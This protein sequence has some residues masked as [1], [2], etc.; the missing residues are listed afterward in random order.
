MN[1][2]IVYQNIIKNLPVELVKIINEYVDEETTFVRDKIVD[3]LENKNT[4]YNKIKHK[5]IVDC[6]FLCNNIR[7]NFFN[8]NQDLLEIIE[9][10]KIIP[11]VFKKRKTFNHMTYIDYDSIIQIWELLENIKSPD[12]PIINNKINIHCFYM[13]LILLDFKIHISQLHTYDILQFQGY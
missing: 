1:S 9:L 8:Y 6:I 13:A 2:V 4:G 11:S 12:Y 5:K 7:I 10:T 3:F